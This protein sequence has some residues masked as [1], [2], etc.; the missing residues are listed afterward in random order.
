MGRG[1]A[2]IRLTRAGDACSAEGLVATAGR[3]GNANDRRGQRGLRQASASAL[4]AVSPRSV[5]FA[6]IAFWTIVSAAFFLGHDA[7]TYL[8]AGERLNAGHQLYRLSAG[9]RP[10]ELDP[11]YW[12]VPLLSPPLI[13]VVWRPLAAL[14]FGTGMLVWMGAHAIALLWAALSSVTSWRSALLIAILA[15]G[16]GLELAAGNVVGF[17]A[18]GSVVIWRRREAW[19]IGALIGVMA[20]VKLMPVALIA[21][22]VARRDLR[23]LAAFIVAALLALAVSVLG[24][25]VESHLAYLHVA[26]SSAPQPWS[27]AWIVGS[28]WISMA[29]LGCGLVLSTFLD[30]RPA[31]RLSLAATVLCAPG[32]GWGS[33]TQLVGLNEQGMKGADSIMASGA[34]Q[35]PAPGTGRSSVHF[36]RTRSRAF[37]QPLRPQASSG[38]GAILRP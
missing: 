3:L 13:A 29:I 4:R 9:D 5:A 19:W 35:A 33:L 32:L 30:D 24:A 6:A 17:I 38:P 10:I 23:Q 18:A 20:A 2:P 25:G 12:S 21:L 28:P 16:I 1:P 14:P 8:A 27:P 31:Y 15:P 34:V 22:V 36:A 26:Q 11:P 37:R 7:T